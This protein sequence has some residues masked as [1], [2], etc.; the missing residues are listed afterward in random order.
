MTEQMS[1]F[2]EPVQQSTATAAVLVRSH[3]RHV[4]G[5]KPTAPKEPQKRTETING[6]PRQDSYHSDYIS[7]AP[8]NPEAE[9]ALAS[10]FGLKSLPPHNGTQTSRAAAESLTSEHLQAQEAR[11]LSALR[12]VGSAGLIREQIASMTG[13]EL[14]DV[15]RVVNGLA[16]VTKGAEKANRPKL[17]EDGPQTR[18][19]SHGRSQKVVRAL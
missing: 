6:L 15:C 9:K 2:N 7:E 4:K 1:L 13:L 10:V 18:R 17:V 5:G 8:S 3:L 16:G 14:T 11:V 19:S 12:S